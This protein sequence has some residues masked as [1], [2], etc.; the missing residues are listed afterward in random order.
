[1][2]HSIQA[3]P[4]DYQGVRFR[5]KSEAIFARAMDL[6]GIWWEYEPDTFRLG[7]FFDRYRWVPDFLVCA[8]FTE[9]CGKPGLENYIIEYKPSVPSDTYFSKLAGCAR[10]IVPPG[11]IRIPFLVIAVD[12]F[13]DPEGMRQWRWDHNTWR[14]E[15]RTNIS[16]IKQHIKSARNYRFDLDTS[17]SHRN[18][19]TPEKP[20]PADDLESAQRRAKSLFQAMRDAANK[21]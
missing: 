16:F 6:A 10:A 8:R 21:A 11:K 14:S 7:S 4:T 20:L 3:T 17:G 5:S 13:G 9:S 2:E 1:M 12:V 18:Q 15:V 19:P